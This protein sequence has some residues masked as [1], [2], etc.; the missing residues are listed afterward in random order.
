MKFELDYSEAISNRGNQTR[1]KELMKK[2]S[3]GGR[4]TL[5]FFGGSITQ[6][7]VT[8]RPELC[9]A[10]RVYDWFVKTF[11]KAEFV[12]LNAG[13]G[14]TT[15]QFGVAR[16]QDDL[17][18]Y[19]PDFAIVEF[20]VNDEPNEHFLETYE[21]LVRKVL[22]AP[23]HPAL[24]L[25]HNVYYH[26]GSSAQPQHSR[27]GRHYQLPSVSMQSTI[28]KETVSGRIPNREITHDDLHP[29]DEGHGLVASVITYLLDDVHAHM[30]EAE[31]AE[32]ALPAPMSENA[33]E[34]SE[35]IRNDHA[36][37][38]P[39]LKGFVADTAPCEGITDDA[40]FAKGWTAGKVGDELI[41]HVNA[42]NIAVQYRETIHLP[43]PVAELILDGD[44]DHP[45][46]LDSNFK[47]TWGE[48]LRLDT[49]LEHGEKR[50]HEVKVRIREAHPE[51][52]KPFYLV[53]LIT[54]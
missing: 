54:S 5:G 31:E 22:S 21:G 42:A 18:S 3:E 4:Y 9:Y 43:G 14:G 30:T 16:V 37:V 53:S 11:P 46:I 26:S 24:M 2:A 36:S 23:S 41:F 15:S 40:R 20:S 12:Y 45:F 28:Y 52:R 50:E 33:Y 10:H 44:T 32:A 8:T 19:E 51:D 47:E 29:N 34:T 35:R 49:I 39:L 17:L 7:A 1:L 6:G 27:V 38:K 13:I 48:N 25:V